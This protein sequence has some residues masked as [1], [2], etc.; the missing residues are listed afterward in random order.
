MKKVTI[1]MPFLNEATEP[2]ETIKSI[3]D[4]ASP[5]L[6]EIIVIDDDSK[7]DSPD[8]SQFKDVKMV[9]NKFRI[10][11]DG[12]RQLGVEM[13]QTPQVLIIDA[14]M[15]FKNDQWLDKL[16]DCVEKEPKTVWCT[17][18]LGLGYGIMDPYK[19][20]SKYYAA[21]M[22]FLNPD[23]TPDRPAR[24]VLEPKWMNRQN[25]QE[26]EVPCVLG[27][28]Y[29]IDREWYNYIGG[30]KG[31]KM[32]GTSEPFLSMKSWMAGGKCKITTDVEIGHVFRTNAPYVTRV[33]SLIY[34]K[35]F[36][37]KTIL[38]EELGKKLIGYLFQDSGVFKEAAAMIDFN[39][40]LIE[41]EQQ[42]Y[43]QILKST[44]YDYCDR[45][46]IELP[47]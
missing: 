14:H 23:A 35:I 42:Y 11:V 33:S 45:F 38:P 20:N 10:G 2:I 7:H 6:F 46:K 5:D 19:T 13:A 18:C 44:I 9:R 29:A 15:R 4:T 41:K 12:S 1:V 39:A 36:L 47:K 27:A 28:N 40:K 31:L 3:Y 25:N 43:G 34:N 30:L 21:T 24:E 17:T 37:C 8:F 26:Y 32:W 22:M 16:I